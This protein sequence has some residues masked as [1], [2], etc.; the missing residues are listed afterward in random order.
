MSETVEA[1]LFEV[2]EAAIAKVLEI[3][4]NEDD[5]EALG[6]RIEITG[7]SAGRLMCHIW[8]RREAPSTVADSYSSGSTRESC[9]R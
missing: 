1:Q 5:P 2:T 9:A 6:L 8:R 4:S 7:V 3:R